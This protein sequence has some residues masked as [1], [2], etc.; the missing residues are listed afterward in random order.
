[1]AKKN[2]ITSM[3]ILDVQISKKSI[4]ISFFIIIF[5]VFSLVKLLPKGSIGGYI[6]QDGKPVVGRTVR[7]SMEKIDNKIASTKTDENGYYRFRF[8]RSNIYFVSINS[9]S[10]DGG[11]GV[12][13]D[14]KGNKNMLDTEIT[15]NYKK[16]T[17]GVYLSTNQNINDLNYSVNW[18]GNYQDFPEKYTSNLDKYKGLSL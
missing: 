2:K 14:E 11:Y 4:F 8:L 9:S 6:A 12:G 15:F 10:T 7:L 1:M 18:P 3:P 17:T 16:Q 13:Y 5:L